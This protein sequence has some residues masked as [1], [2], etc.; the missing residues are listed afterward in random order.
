MKYHS[1]IRSSATRLAPVIL[2]ICAFGLIQPSKAHAQQ[3]L[4]FA[5]GDD[6]S[7]QLVDVVDGN[8]VF[9]YKGAEI[10]IPAAEIRSF[11]AP[12]PIGIRLADST[13]V[14]A[15]VR[16]VEDG[17]LL[18]LADGTTRL[19]Q[20]ADFE[21]VGSADDLKALEPI[22]IGLYSPFFKFWE[23]LVAMGGSFQRGNTDETNFSFS[24]D[25]GR[26]TV[27]D[28]TE[29]SVLATTTR[30]FD[31][32]GLTTK[33][34]PKIIV[35]LGT[36]IFITPGGLFAGVRMRWQ[37][38]PVKDLEFRQVYSGSFG[39]QFVQNDNTNLLASLGFGGRFDNLTTID[40][41]SRDTPI[42]DFAGQFRQ[43][44]G[45]VSFR[46]RISYD[47]SLQNFSNF[48]LLNALDI[49][50]RLVEGLTFKWTI[51]HEHNNPPPTEDPERNDLTMTFQLGWAAGK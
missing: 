16:P 46:L 43:R 39:Y 14:A 36:D 34:E 15:A 22:I 19:V 11:T 38:D 45:P 3:E 29:F 8:W 23:T 44:A 7:G 1:S 25:L 17:L 28:R 9:S 26:E 27:K 10:S 5:D 31:D 42:L 51:L 33:N 35:S 50:I 21:A 32:A 30:E 6:I 40:P 24:L 47:P 18:E 37:H 20:P 41:S 2:T 4:V 48:E 12:E 13:V 49:G